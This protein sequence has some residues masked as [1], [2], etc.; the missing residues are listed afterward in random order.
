MEE[1]EDDDEEEEEEEGEEEKVS[2][3]EEE[4]TCVDIPAEI[5]RG[6]R[7]NKSPE[8]IMHTLSPVMRGD[9]ADAAAADED[10]EAEED[11][12]AA[13]TEKSTCFPATFPT[14]CRG[15]TFPFPPWRPR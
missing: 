3:G 7:T 9:E 12:V 11:G 2:Q 10:D 8:Q 4:G 15:N 5:S 6:I 14:E 1:D 13:N